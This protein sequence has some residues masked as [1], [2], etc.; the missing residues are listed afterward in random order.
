MDRVLLNPDIAAPDP[1]RKRPGEPDGA[2][3]LGGRVARKRGLEDRQS[4]SGH[5]EQVMARW[6]WN[7]FAIGT[8]S[9]NRRRSGRQS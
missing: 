8:V 6:D 7:Q 5:G 4:R 1:E 3:V 9:I 2:R